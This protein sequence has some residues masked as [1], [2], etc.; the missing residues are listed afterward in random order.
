MSSMPPTAVSPL[1]ALVTD[2][3]GECS[4][5]VTPH[6]C[7]AP[8]AACSAQRAGAAPLLSASEPAAGD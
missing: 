5:G 4:A 3:S 6:T 7:A 1:M 8:R 2:I